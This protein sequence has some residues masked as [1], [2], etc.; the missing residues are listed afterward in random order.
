MFVFCEASRVHEKKFD[1]T[2]KLRIQID[3]SSTFISF[4]CLKN[5]NQ[6]AHSEVQRNSPAMLKPIFTLAVF[7]VLSAPIL[8]AQTA[9]NLTAERWNSLPSNYSVIELQKEGVAKR[10]ADA[11]TLLAGAEWAPSQGDHYGLR[12][13]GAV[14]PPE[15]GDYTF[16]IAGDDNAELYLSTDSSRFHKKRIAWNHTW[17]GVKQWDKLP[18]QRSVSINLVAGQKYYIEAQMMEWGGGDHLSIGWTRT[19]VNWTQDPVA[20]ASQSSTGW[21]GVAARAIDGNT[22]GNYNNNSVTHTTDGTD[23]Y[24]QVNLGQDREIR[25]LVIWPRMA[26]ME[27]LSNFR[28]SIL[29][30]QGA[31]LTGQDY[32]TQQGNVTAPNLRWILPQMVTGRTVRVQFLGQNLAGNGLLSLAEVEVMSQYSTPV[33][34]PSTQLES[35]AA[36]A[37]DADDD[38]LP[39]DWEVL[40]GLDAS[41]AIGNEG[42]Y[43]DY[44]NDGINNLTEY[45]LGTNPAQKEAL[46]DGL[47][48]ERWGDITGNRITDLTH[49]RGRFLRQPSER[50]H[51]PNIDENT[52]G[53]LYATR[54]RGTVNATV[55]GNYTFWIA[56]DDEAELWIADGAVVK[57]IGGTSAALTNRYGKQK[58][59]WIQDQRFG[60]NYTTDEDFD[61]FATQRSRTVYLTAGQS[62]YIEVLH[63]E[64]YSN[65]HVA[66]AWQAPG[67]QRMIIPSSVFSSDVPEDDDMDDDYLP[68]AW[69]TQYG[70]NPADNG[71]TDARDGQYGDWDNDGLTNFEEYQLGTDPTNADS[72]GD[73][74]TDKEERDYYGTD[75]LTS[76]QIAQSLHT[77]MVLTQYQSASSP[78]Y[79][80]T[81]GSFVSAGR[82]G[83]IDYAFTVAAGEEG[84]FE[85][86]LTGG[87]DGVPR[88][89]ESLPLEF[90]LNDNAIGMATLVSLNGASSSIKHLTPWLVAGNYVLRINH[91]NFRAALRL[92]LDSV[93]VTRLGGIDTNS[94]GTADWVESKLADENKITCLP[95]QSAVSPLCVEAYT[96]DAAYAT[97]GKTVID[98]GTGLSVQEAQSWIK[99]VNHGIY[100]NVPLNESSSTELTA[101]FQNGAISETRQVN[102][103][104]TNALATDSITIRKDDSLRLTA[105]NG[106]SAS[107][108]FSLSLSTNPALAPP[109]AGDFPDHLPASAAAAV[110]A[111]SGYTLA[112][113]VSASGTIQGGWQPASTSAT[114][115]HVIVTGNTATL[116]L[117]FFDG[118][119]TKVAKVQLDQSGNDIVAHQIYSRYKSGDHL[120]EN[121]DTNSASSAPNGSGGYGVT[122]LNLTLSYGQPEVTLLTPPAGQASSQPLPF[123]FGVA[124]THTLTATWQP[125]GGGAAVISTLAVTV[126]HADFGSGIDVMTYSQRSWETPGVA[127]GLV[128]EA[129]A[130]LSW[131]EENTSGTSA[132]RFNV[133]TYETGTRHTLARLPGGGAILARGD[134]RGF[135]IAAVDETSDATMVSQYADGTYLM[136]MTVVADNLP[137]NARIRIRSYFQGTTFLNGGNELDLTAA[138]FDE[139]GIAYIYMEWANGAS[140]PKMCHYIDVFLD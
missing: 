75:P 6:E 124:G 100:A 33:L 121:F 14:T 83:V 98:P 41:N 76:N 79:E 128:I 117:Q 127:Q 50:I 126:I 106:V 105:W 88:S 111:W 32:Y 131:S 122:D 133:N 92:R 129:D 61:R 91:N 8:Q 43:G 29:D 27:R 25:E 125:D 107:G 65:D 10:I 24:W 130:A 64:S 89:A 58:L 13:R 103:V 104:S 56:G 37:N 45:Q 34:V 114:A 71:I 66:V 9:G 77:Q 84:I 20:V 36:D 63:K 86:N 46:L 78:W 22:D 17:T 19:G 70:L 118:N 74:L 38:N 28:V 40:H 59:A 5:S 82:R 85:I 94:N 96:P 73:T 2:V 12:L 21:G 55:T 30:A 72:D 80:R 54:Y 57:D 101:S 132:R 138:D 11:T 42:Q 67:G 15:T 90:S 3:V 4:T 135:A 48:R 44:D 134:V 102:W 139:N 108:T 81:D 49:N 110:T 1:F 97:L 47:T 120:G 99:G 16:F 53:D 23:Q 31:E 7:M 35:L 136:R 18:T 93:N 69:E 112:D 51:V 109:V 52:Q 140:A 119:Y 62:Y 39:D 116:Q 95:T 26:N 68:S 87:A 60:K 113:L 115:Y 123:A 137:A